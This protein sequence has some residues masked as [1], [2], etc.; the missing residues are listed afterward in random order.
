MANVQDASGK[1]DGRAVE[2]TI[3]LCGG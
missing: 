2:S 3:S 1:P